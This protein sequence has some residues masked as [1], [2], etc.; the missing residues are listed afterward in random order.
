MFSAERIDVRGVDP[1]TVDSY[2]QSVPLHVRI[3]QY[4]KRGPRTIKEIA[5][6]AMPKSTANHQSR[7]NR[8]GIPRKITSAATVSTGSLSWNGGPHEPDKCP[9]QHR[10]CP[11]GRTLTDNTP[12][13]VLSCPVVR[14]MDSIQ[15]RT[16]ARNPNWRDEGSTN[17]SKSSAVFRLFFIVDRQL[18]DGP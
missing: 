5:E 1:T 4:L 17:H 7:R 10:T 16:N 11:S 14:C 2:A 13:R 9:G 8:S 12:L 18:K 6:E 15:T 3:A